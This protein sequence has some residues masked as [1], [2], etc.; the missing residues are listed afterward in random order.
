MKEV[1]E[2]FNLIYSCADPEWF[3]EIRKLEPLPIDW[4]IDQVKNLKSWVFRGLEM[5]RNS[6]SLHFRVVPS[7]TQNRKDLAMATTLWADIE[8]IISEE[9]KEAMKD[10]NILP[11]AIVCSGR[12]MHMYFALKKPVEIGRAKILN[13]S[14]A[15]LLKGDE[16]AGHPS[17]TLRFPGSYNYKYIPKK[18]VTVEIFGHLYEP[19]FFD[20]LP[21]RKKKKNGKSSDRVSRVSPEK[22]RKMAKTCPVIE[23]ALEKP[24]KLSFFAWSSLACITD[25]DTFIEISRLDTE[26]F[27]EEEA[28]RQYRYLKERNYRPYGCDKLKEAKNCQRK[29]RCGLKKVAYEQNIKNP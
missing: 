20:T 8:R 22:M 29:G 17:H 25:E 28:R 3:L 26:R 24:E 4:H 9:E 15:Y 1:Y 12:G 19:E 21:K 13:E 23:I 27:R 7:R 16:G 18:L 10:L 5:A 6:K 11:S 14:L 2:F